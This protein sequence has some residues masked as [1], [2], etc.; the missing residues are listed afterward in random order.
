[1]ASKIRTTAPNS[2][3]SKHRVLIRGIALVA[4]MVVLLLAIGRGPQRY[5]SD[6]AGQP[7]GWACLYL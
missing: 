6:A 4:A 1:M 3:S 2:V 7:I 5:L